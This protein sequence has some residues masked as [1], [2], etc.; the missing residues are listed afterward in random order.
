MRESESVTLICV[1]V[2]CHSQ[3]CSCLV[4]KRCLLILEFCWFEYSKRYA[5]LRQRLVADR[6]VLKVSASCAKFMPDW[7]FKDVAMVIHVAS[8][9][10]LTHC[11]IFIYFR[12]IFKW[13][14]TKN[15]QTI[16]FDKYPQ[17]S[18]EELFKSLQNKETTYAKVF[19]VICG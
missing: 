11:V 1:E 5:N 4:T 8:L 18:A 12:V 19:A 2:S 15:L 14:T 17:G 7:R 9:L 10:H 3:T 13:M 16:K 6:T